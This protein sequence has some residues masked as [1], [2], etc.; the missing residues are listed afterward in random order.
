MSPYSVIGKST[1]GS[2]LADPQGADMIAIPCTPGNGIVKR[3]TVMYR[4][5]S[6]MYAPATSAECVTTKYL[7]VLDETVDTSADAKVAEDARAY[8]AG[9]M[10]HGKVTLKNDA[11]LDAAAILVLRKQ[12]ITFGQMTDTAEEFKNETGG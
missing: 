3:G 9:R 6:G 11:K 7:A 1:P 8:R 5:D 10:L 2:L 12:G 4:E